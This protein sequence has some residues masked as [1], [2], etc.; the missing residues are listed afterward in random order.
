MQFLFDFPLGFQGNRDVA[1][2][3]CPRPPCELVPRGHCH[4]CTHL[5]GKS[6]SRSS[7][8]LAECLAEEQGDAADSPAAPW[9][10]NSDFCEEPSWRPVSPQTHSTPPARLTM[11]TVFRFH[12][13]AQA[14][15]PLCTGLGVSN[16][17]G[18][19][20]WHY[21]TTICPSAWQSESSRML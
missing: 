7:H 10:G 17:G 8:L 6:A 16:G 2:N 4:L 9:E 18:S 11:G 12:A 15:F 13:R 14:I 19:A 1:D 3:L 5:L 21:L 20:R